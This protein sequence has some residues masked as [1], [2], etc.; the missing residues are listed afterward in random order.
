MAGPLQA[1]AM[2]WRWAAARATG[3]SHLRSGLPC[4]DRFGVEIL[5]NGVLIATL[6]DGAGSAIHG[7]V[8]AETAVHTVLSWLHESLGKENPDLKIIIQEAVWKARQAVMAVAEK[9]QQDPRQYASTL[10]VVA[11]SQEGG[12]VAQIG[13]GVIVV[14]CGDEEWT[15]LLWPQ[16][17]EYTNTT[18]F[19]TDPHANQYLQVESFP[20]CITDLALMSDGLECLALRYADQAVHQ[21]FCN[22]MFQPLL[23]AQDC[24]EIKP[25]SNAL[26]QYL[27]SEPISSRTDDDVS[28]ILATRRLAATPT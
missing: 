2:K 23:V 21:P 11:L 5:P 9:E 22:G 24:D 20:G 25:L 6:A 19:L 13:D 1:E 15:W 16:R 3:R 12:A 18:F 26:M 4:Q 17:G 8:G 27:A 10:L 7:E 14:K 28:I